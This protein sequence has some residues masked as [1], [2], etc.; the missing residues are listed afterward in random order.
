[1]SHSFL[2]QLET[3]PDLEAVGLD[4]E[5]LE[6]IGQVDHYWYEFRS[7]G[8][9]A[10]ASIGTQVFYLRQRVRNAFSASVHGRQDVPRPLY[11]RSNRGKLLPEG[12]QN[13]VML[14]QA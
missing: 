12:S 4:T 1:M 3:L 5:T 6:K 13:P 2:W 10:I 8:T 14:I 11:A 9:G 7:V